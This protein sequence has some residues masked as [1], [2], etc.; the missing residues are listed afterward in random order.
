MS[1]IAGYLPASSDPP[2]AH[3]PT[4]TST[5]PGGTSAAGGSSAARGRATTCRR[6]VHMI[7]FSKNRA[8]QLDQLL[9]SSKRHLQLVQ[10]KGRDSE[11]EGQEPAQLRISVLYV[12]SAARSSDA[13]PDMAGSG[14]GVVA[15]QEVWPAGPESAPSPSGSDR[16][17][18]ESYDIVRCRHPD[19]RFVR[20]R[21]GEFCDQLCSL[22]REETGE[23]APASTGDGHEG[24]E[25]RFVLFAVDDMFFYRDFELPGALELLST[26]D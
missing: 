9:G 17:M 6:V 13:A 1:M 3:N 11:G 26:G 5:K 22:V 12:A 23:P 18:E 21:P 7:C 25:E 15:E 20:E 4:P 10:E 14:V 8:F 2:P 19:V 16:T 24:R